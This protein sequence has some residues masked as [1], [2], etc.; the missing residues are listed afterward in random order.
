[1]VRSLE[2]DG[3][4]GISFHVV[5]GAASAA[6]FYGRDLANLRSRNKLATGVV[7]QFF[8]SSVVFQFCRPFSKVQRLY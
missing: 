3:P 4:R 5:S 8:S 6:P 1:M 7:F 2:A